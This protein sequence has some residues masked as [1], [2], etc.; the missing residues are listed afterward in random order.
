MPLAYPMSRLKLHSSVIE[1]FDVESA[2]ETSLARP[3]QFLPPSP[4]DLAVSRNS[5]EFDEIFMG[6]LE[7]GVDVLRAEELSARKG[8]RGL[9]PIPI[10]TFF[11]RVTYQGL[12]DLLAPKLPPL[13]RS[14]DDYKAFVLGPTL[15]AGTTHVVS[16][17]VAAFYQY[18]DHE[19]V[20]EELVS[21]TGDFALARDVGS[22][23]HATQGRGVGLPQGFQPSDLL[24]EV[25]IDIAERRL[26][27]RGL[28]VW[29]YNDDFRFATSS[30][31]AA[32]EAVEALDSELRSLGFTL[33]EEKLH[34]HRMDTYALYLA[35][36]DQA[37][38]QAADEIEINVAVLDPYA[39]TLAIDPDIDEFTAATALRVLNRWHGAVVGDGKTFGLDGLVNRKI[40]RSAL[41][42]LSSVPTTDAL[43]HLRNLLVFEPG[44]TPQ[45]T[46]FLTA[47][48]GVDEPAVLTALGE[49]VGD[50]ELFLSPWQHSWLASVCLQSDA[51]DEVLVTWLRDS[52]E[53]ST[54]DHLRARAAFALAKH[55]RSDLQQLQTLYELVHPASRPDVVAALTVQSFRDGIDPPGA[56]LRDNPANVWIAGAVVEGW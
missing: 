5:D 38:M 48:Q 10:L 51:I 18:V 44:L 20:M 31:R 53:N 42:W 25:V 17:D 37:L 30:W 39:G 8:V 43:Q 54:L 52:V 29:R 27:R 3:P 40:A 21:Q 56:I 11:D 45:I 2:R 22:F 15:E 7:N 32:L 12:T 14:R 16:A 13:R 33:N 4:M 28:S 24:S 26:L 19:L 47:L 9:R 1:S 35:A 34:F 36:P 41:Q 46:L 49:I 55:G 23:L 6:N 50:S